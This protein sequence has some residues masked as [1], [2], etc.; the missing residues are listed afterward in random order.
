MIIYIVFE[1]DYVGSELIGA[2]SSEEKA[3]EMVSKLEEKY[4]GHYFI[5]TTLLMEG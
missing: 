5:K 2:Y 4:G 3:K 1:F